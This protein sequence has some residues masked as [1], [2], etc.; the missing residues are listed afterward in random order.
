LPVSR[1]G[2]DEAGGFSARLAEQIA[3]RE[4]TS[5]R[6]RFR[7]ISLRD[8]QYLVPDNVSLL[9][10]HDAQYVE[11][12]HALALEH[13]AE[14]HLETVNYYLPGL[15]KVLPSNLGLEAAARFN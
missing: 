7:L 3:A 10:G 14:F 6:G 4:E 12:R 9:L 13:H 1:Q 2:P 8:A 11:G 15:K 5:G